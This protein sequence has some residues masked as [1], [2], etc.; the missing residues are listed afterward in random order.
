MDTFEQEAEIDIAAVQ[1]EIDRL[2]GELVATRAE[3]R[4]YLA[5]LGFVNEGTVHPPGADTAI[6][7]RAT[8]AEAR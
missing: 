8:R 7:G 4:R 1:G 3:M 5:E 2:E 6:N